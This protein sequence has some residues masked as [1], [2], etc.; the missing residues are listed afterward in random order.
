M[1]VG[2]VLLA[3]DAFE[4]IFNC[5]IY[6]LYRCTPVKWIGKQRFFRQRDEICLVPKLFTVQD[7]YN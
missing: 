7:A 3:C 1:P 5:I 2:D 6:G 4:K